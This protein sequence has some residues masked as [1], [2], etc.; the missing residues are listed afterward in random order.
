MAIGN[1]VAAAGN[2]IHAGIA[3]ADAIAAS[4]AGSV[5]RGEHGLAP[6]HLEDTGAKKA[7]RRPVISDASYR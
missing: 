3:A 5:W 7:Q 4:R 2:A 6:N 1:N